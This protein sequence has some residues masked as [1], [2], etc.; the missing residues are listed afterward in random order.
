MQKKYRFNASKTYGSQ[1]GPLVVVGRAVGRLD[2]FV[3]V[4]FAVFHFLVFAQQFSSKVHHAG[5]QVVDLR[6]LLFS[7]SY[8]DSL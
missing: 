8:R 7:L 4:F 5:L 3:F 1:I 6:G 2:F